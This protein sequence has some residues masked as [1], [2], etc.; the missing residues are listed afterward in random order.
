MLGKLYM[1]HLTKHENTRLHL[2]RGEWAAAAASANAVITATPTY[3]LAAN[4]AFYSGN[5][6]ED[7]FTI[8]MSTTD[9]SRTRSGGLAGYHR[10]A[11]AGRGDAPFSTSLV[12]TFL[13]EPGDLRLNLSDSAAAS[14][15]PKRRFTLKYPDAKTNSDNAPV[16]RVTE[17]YLNEAE[18]LAQLNG[19]NQPSIDLINGL[20]KRAGLPD[21]TILTFSTPKDLINGILNERRKELVLKAIEEWIY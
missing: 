14:D 15:G 12:N 18:A 3:A 20:R 7:I 10:P 9:N 2:Y 21:W 11:P 1:Q 4:Y 8:E 19:I 13:Q 17:M 5:T 6:A 16:I